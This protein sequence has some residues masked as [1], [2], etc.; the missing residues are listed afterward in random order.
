MT[1]QVVIHCKP[2]IEE[3]KELLSNPNLLISN[4]TEDNEIDVY[5]NNIESLEDDELCKH[6]GINYELVNCIELA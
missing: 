1:H 6:Y 5:V 4:V 3:S 2:E